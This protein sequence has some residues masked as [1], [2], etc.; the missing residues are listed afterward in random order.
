MDILTVA[1]VW[2]QRFPVTNEHSNGCFDYRPSQLEQRMLWEEQ[3]KDEDDLADQNK[4]LELC[5]YDGLMW[6]LISS[7]DREKL[8]RRKIINIKYA[9]HLPCIFGIRKMCTIC[10]EYDRVQME[11]DMSDELEDASREESFAYTEKYYGDWFEFSDD[12]DYYHGGRSELLEWILEG[13]SSDSEDDGA[14][15]K[16]RLY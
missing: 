2:E 12:D 9:K 4:R 1:D 10:Q 14:K 13:G 6:N 11:Q 7:H 15:G 16:Q 8:E 3:C 5:E